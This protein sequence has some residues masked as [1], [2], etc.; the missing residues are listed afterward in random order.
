MNSTTTK[1]LIA[2]SFLV[3]GPAG[4]AAARVN[5]I[6]FTLVQ[7]EEGEIVTGPLR[8]GHRVEVF[9]GIGKT[10]LPRRKTSRDLEAREDYDPWMPG[11]VFPT[12]RWRR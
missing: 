8:K 3:F 1:R 2:F 11:R 5:F 7:T 9:R 12:P 6:A 4:V 10:G